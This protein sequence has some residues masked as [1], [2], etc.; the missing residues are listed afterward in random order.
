MIWF[1]EA[2]MDT[3]NILSFTWSCSEP[4]TFDNS[5]RLLALDSSGAVRNVKVPVAPT[6]CLSRHS[7]L[8]L[9]KGSQILES[10]P[11]ILAGDISQVMKERALLGYGADVNS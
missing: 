11:S 7:G 10:K 4:P 1:D 8:R 9:T 3:S 2:S 5:Y 6:Y